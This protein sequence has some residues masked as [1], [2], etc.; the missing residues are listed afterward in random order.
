[1]PP[2]T[3]STGSSPYSTGGG[4]VRLEHS[5]AA[6]LIAGLLAGDALTELGDSLSTDSIRLQA[7]DASEVDDILIEGRDAH[8]EV[9]R[10]S[11]AVRRSPALTRGDSAS[12]PLFRDFLTV[13]IDQW[14]T[15]VAGRWRLVLAVSTNANAITQLADLAE[16]ARSVPSGK[17]LERR[18]VQPGRTNAGVRD[19]YEHIKG[20]VEQ[21]AEGL[22]SAAGLAAVELT[23]RLLSSLTVRTLRLERTDRAD[24]TTAVNTLQRVLHEGT[25]A[26]ADAL[27]SRMEELVGTWASQAAVLTQSVIR[28]ILSDYPLSRSPRFVQR[29]GSPRPAGGA[30]S[31]LDQAHLARW[32]PDSRAG[33]F[34]GAFTPLF[35]YA[36]SRHRT[37]GAR[38][39]W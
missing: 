39:H 18:L 32:H 31:R 14:S 13:V 25:P 15:V 24:R 30:P 11:I 21:A 37:R 38:R 36:I 22:A 3:T 35:S 7:S 8:G 26:T 4:G 34:D 20:L 16:L 2:A 29:V 5:Y 6:C 1:M 33:A 9:Y 19:R 23:W 27:F 12:I 28:R 17:E 10:S